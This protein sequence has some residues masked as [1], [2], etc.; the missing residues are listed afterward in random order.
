VTPHREDHRDVE[1]DVAPHGRAV[2]RANLRQRK[3]GQRVKFEMTEQTREAA[4][5]YI[6]AAN[7]VRS[8]RSTPIGGRP[9]PGFG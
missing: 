3:T 9:R 8:I 2:D 1:K 6:A 7:K 4:D 5:S